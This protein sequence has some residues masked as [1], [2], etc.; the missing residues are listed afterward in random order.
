MTKYNCHLRNFHVHICNLPIRTSSKGLR[1]SQLFI[2]E[3]T[4]KGFKGWDHMMCTGF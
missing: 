4:F 3:F 1:A 2:L